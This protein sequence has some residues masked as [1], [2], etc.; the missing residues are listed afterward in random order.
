[1]KKLLLFFPFLFLYF[2]FCN[3]QFS[4][5]GMT[6]LGGTYNDGVIFKY[7]P[8]SNI[9]TKVLDFDGLNYGR[10]PRGSL[11]LASN[12]KLYG[13]TYLGG[14]ADWGVLFKYDQDSATF[15]KLLDYDMLDVIHGNSPHGSLIQV[16]DG[17][18]YGMT[19]SAGSNNNGVLFEYDI[20]I[21]TYTKKV[22]FYS[23]TTGRNPFGSLMEATNGKL[24]GMTSGSQYEGTLFEYS[25]STSTCTKLLDFY[26]ASNG[27]KPGGS[28]M[29][30][31]N[32]K[33]YG[34]TQ[35]GGVFNYGVLFEYDLISGIYT[36]K[37]DF[38]SINIGCYPSGTLLQ[39]I[40]GKLYGMTVSGGTNNYGVLFEYDITNDTIIKK[41]DF[42]GINTGGGSY[43]SLMQASNG[44]LYGLTM[45]GG[46][47]N[48]GVLFEYDPVSD[49]FSKK[50]DFD[51]ING[52]HPFYTYLIEVPDTIVS[53]ND[54]NI[55]SNNIKIYPNPSNGEF[56]MEH[57][58]DNFINIVI[59]DT[60]GRIMYSE[61][62]LKK[63]NHIS[64]NI[65]PGL[66]FIKISS[67]KGC[68]QKKL[69]I[70]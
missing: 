33:L 49:I 66:Y 6:W 5:W 51:S 53:I 15:I 19:T 14:N 39:A 54:N 21:N 26:G 25:I 10:Y 70:E 57:Q 48:N 29:Q 38:D 43:G 3:A 65:K 31:S 20:F 58:I 62:N 47:Y 55:E 17:K 41:L 36:K 13:M 59:Y 18:L 61:N 24:Y 7:D 52:S 4:L 35:K 22:D 67:D 69:I 32:G 11:M 46:C 1:M 37:V 16:S 8:D 56:I 34:L 30:A 28:L 9:L 44:K 23:P 2:S 63:T 42:D 45:M 12:G 27:A 50:L 64:V 60:Q 40:D 68:M